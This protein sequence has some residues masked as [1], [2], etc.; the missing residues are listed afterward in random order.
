MS[1]CDL[2]VFSFTSDALVQDVHEH[3]QVLKSIDESLDLPGFIKSGRLGV[4]SHDFYTTPLSFYEMPN[5]LKE[6]LSNVSLVITKGDANYRRLLGDGMWP[7]S[8]SFSDAVNYWPTAL[9]AIRTCKSPIIVGV[10]AEVQ[11]RVKTKDTEWL[12]NGNYGVLQFKP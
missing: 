1:F 6:L 8:A 9:L 12:L 2:H 5:D 7:H 11:D 3:I 10:A 4:E